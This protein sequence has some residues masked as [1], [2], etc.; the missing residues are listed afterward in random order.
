MHNF[1]VTFYIKGDINMKKF[2]LDCS[3]NP[4]FCEQKKKRKNKEILYIVIHNTGNSSDT[5][6]NNAKYFK[7]N[8]TRYAGATFIIGGK[9]YRYQCCDYDRITYSVGGNQYKGF[10]RTVYPYPTNVNTISIELTDIVNHNITSKQLSALKKTVREIKK[11]CPNVIDIIRHY[12][13]NGKPCPVRYCSN[14]KNDK[15][16][17]TLK[18]KLIK[19]L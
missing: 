9:G 11:N 4:M 7:N 6:E 8:T 16:W 18:K 3:K 19:C 2:K 17:N 1:S 10:K 12:D 13:V 14:S 5:A 15:K